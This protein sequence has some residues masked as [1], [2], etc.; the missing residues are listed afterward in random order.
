MKRTHVKK[1]VWVIVPIAI[2]L[3]ILLCAFSIPFIAISCEGFFMKFKL[4]NPHIDSHYKGWQNVSLEGLNSFCIPEGWHVQND[5]GLYT[6]VDDSG[7]P[8]AYGA[9]YG[10]EN[11]RFDNYSELLTTV[12]SYD[13]I[14]ITF[15]PFTRFAMMDGSDI[16][17]L[18]IQGGTVE[19]NVF[20]LQMM[21]SVQTEFVWFLTADI[22]SSSDQY[23]I[24]E[25]IIYSYAY[26]KKA[27]GR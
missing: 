25:A 20:C 19:R 18:V 13:D 16:D 17:L 14:K 10:T 26:E 2:I 6:I 21:E 5:S 8:W 23:D 12:F 7:D 3:Q 11:D 4:D 15:D 9:F 24:A 22:A 1:L 27:K